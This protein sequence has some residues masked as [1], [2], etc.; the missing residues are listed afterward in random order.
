MEASQAEPKPKKKFYKKWWFWVLVVILFFILVGS[1]NS[2]PHVVGTQPAAEATQT[3]FRIGDQV[4][5]G[6]T[7][8]T[9]TSVNKDWHSSNEFDKPQSP[10]D[11]YVVVTVSIANKGTDALNVSGMFDF[12]LQ[13]ATGAQ[14]DMSL[15]GIGLNSLD[16]VSSIAPNG[17]ATGDV[18]FEVPSSAISNMS[19]VYQPLFSLGSPV[20][21]QL[22]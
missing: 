17:T 16:Q 2:T 9:V 18:L 12:K 15:G 8:L 4:Q 5:E 22:Q 11:Q 1:H 19:L 20:M 10:S 6:D 7:V 13:D 14:H 21:I 3:T